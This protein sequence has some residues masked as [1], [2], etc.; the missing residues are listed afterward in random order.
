MDPNRRRTNETKKRAAALCLLSSAGFSGDLRL[1]PPSLSG[2]G[3]TFLYHGGHGRVCGPEQLQE[4]I[5]EPGFFAGGKKYGP[6][7]GRLPA[8]PA[9]T[10]PFCGHPAVPA[11]RG[12][13]LEIRVSSAHGDALRHG[14]FDMED[15]IFGGRI[16]EPGAWHA[17]RFYGDRTFILGAGVQLCVEKPGVYG[18][19][20]AGGDQWRAFRYGRS[21]AGGR[22]RS[23]PDMAVRHTAPVKRA[24]L[25]HYG[26]VLSEYLQILPGSLSGG[27]RLSPGKNVSAVPSVQ[28]L[29]RGAGFGQDGRRG[30]L[31]GGSTAGLFSALL[32]RGEKE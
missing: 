1:Y 14:G 31:H 2:C 3:Q 11:A 5:C 17:D 32:L 28:Q 20:L 9:G 30:G 16:F 15:G 21:R 7:Y 22:R 18:G 6:L 10:G 13:V 27:R 4:N 12:A 8:P 19:A 25:H 26:A 23:D 24:V 29:V